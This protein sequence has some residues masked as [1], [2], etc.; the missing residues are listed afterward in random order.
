MNDARKLVVALGVVLAAVAFGAFVWVW[1][2]CRISVGPGMMAIVT[3]KTGEEL[4]PGAI[5]AEPGQKGV[6]RIP[7]AEGRHFLN[8]ITHDWHLVPA[9]TVSAA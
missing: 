4:P 8:P 2:F 7:L 3:A 6:Q 5:L 9:K 1:F